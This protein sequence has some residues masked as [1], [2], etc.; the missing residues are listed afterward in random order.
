[1]LTVIERVIL[2]Q[3]VDVFEQVSTEQL[4]YLAAIAREVEFLE[5]DTIYRENE[6]AVAMY[7]VL[8]GSVRLHQ[9][10]LDITI[11][12]ARDAFGTWSLFDDRPTVVTATAL[13]HTRLLRVDREDFID[14]LADHVQIAQGVLKKMAGRLRGLASR[15]GSEPSG[16]RTGR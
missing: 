9:N 7:L 4:A 2:L 12:R 11:A 15:I 1:M 16:G 3:N 13:E 5:G 14:L 10:N 8:E 6:R